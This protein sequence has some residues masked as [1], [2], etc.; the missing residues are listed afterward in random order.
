MAVADAGST[1]RGGGSSFLAPILQDFVAPLD[2]GLRFLELPWVD[3]VS[4]VARQFAEEQDGL[5]LLHCG[6]LQRCE[7]APHD[8]GPVVAA[9]PVVQPFAHSLGDAETTGA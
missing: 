7:M 9:T 3:Q 6:R 8:G 1:A 4:D 2:K 5:D